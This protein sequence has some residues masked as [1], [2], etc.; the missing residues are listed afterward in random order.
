MRPVTRRAALLVL[1]GLLLLS[2]NLRPAA[3]SVGPVLDEVRAG[4]DMSAA[5]AGLLTSMPVLAFAVFGALAA[6]AARRIGI[7]RVTLLSLLAVTGGLLGRVLVDGEAAFLVLSMV[8]VAGMAMAN[9]LLPSLVKKHFPDRIG[10]VTAMYTTALAVGLTGALMLT[11]PMAEAF[12]G[13]RVGLGLWSVL[14]LVAVLPWL[15]LITHDVRVDVA[16]RSIRFLDIART[17]LGLAMAGFFGLQSLQAYAVFGWFATLWRDA[18]F[19]AA[20]AGALVGVVA[21]MSIPLSLWAPAAMAKP[22]D[23]RWVLAVVLLC[24]PVSYVGLV[25]AP[26]SLAVLWALVLGVAMASFPI[27]LVL[28]GLRTR[29]SE[30][31][32]ALSGFTQATGYLV[33]AA[34]PF[35]VG[36]LRELTGGWTVPL[37]VLLALSV[38]LFALGMYLGK[39]AALEDQL[40]P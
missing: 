2:L 27:V 33:A 6:L 38:P 11:V 34:G 12:G 15:A 8:A 18:G 35:G 39:P 25:V 37:L 28:I 10:P 24:Y 13:W 9:V 36:T 17:P 29:T 3:V 20:A 23:R 22:G 19:S 16:P 4:L 7:H 1:A 21:A 31:T 30:G 14:A 5:S 32:A 40:R 26:H